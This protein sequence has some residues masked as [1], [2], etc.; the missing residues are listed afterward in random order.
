M[1]EEL[2]LDASHYMHLLMDRV[3][4]MLA[5]W[6]RDLRCRF[7]NRAYES[8]FGVNPDHLIGISIQDLLGP[9]LFE[10]NE[11]HMRKVLAG[12]RQIFER[13]IPGPGGVMR[14]SLAEYIPDEVDGVVNG[15]L[16]QVT[17][18]TELKKTQAALSKEH[19]LRLQIEEQLAQLQT[20]LA[21]R[22]EMLQILA[23]EV[24]QPLNNAG[25]ALQT[26]VGALRGPG[27]GAASDRVLRAQTVLG[28][29][30]TSIDN[31]LAVASLLARPDPI[32]LDDTDIQTLIDVVIADMP[33]AERPR[34][35]ID[36]QTATR[37]ALMDMSLMRLA[38]RNV[39]FN[40]LKFSTPGSEVW[41]RIADSDAPLALLIDVEDHGPGIPPALLPRLFLR[42]ARGDQ[43]R[44]GHGLGLYIVQRVLAL[45]GGTAELV[46]TGPEG[47]TFRLV[48]A[49][50]ELQTG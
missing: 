3:P 29:V 23:H 39:V 36:R 15:F 7:A 16:V 42:G 25:A 17:N 4:S 47:S 21:E 31:T 6:D 34:I 43:R 18:L 49:Q 5:Y 24:R 19:E 37:T 30:I 28:E 35:R 41:L 12:E 11:P 33:V 22:T 8:W 44:R 20:L 10:L 50:S 27:E 13:L 14:N 46:R 32:Q 2:D 9:E 45:H 40:A 48:I 26:A 38:L 1:N